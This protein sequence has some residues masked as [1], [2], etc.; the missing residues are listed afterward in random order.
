MRKVCKGESLI[1][2]GAQELWEET[3]GIKTERVNDYCSWCHECDKH[4]ESTRDLKEK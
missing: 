1:L 4:V 3:C 2:S